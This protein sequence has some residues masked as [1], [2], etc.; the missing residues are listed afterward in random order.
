MQHVNKYII[1]TL[2]DVKTLD[3]KI[4]ELRDEPGNL[5]LLLDVMGMI[6][7]DAESLVQKG[8]MIK[9][10]DIV[11][12]ILANALKADQIK[13]QD[14][15]LVLMYLENVFAPPIYWQYAILRVHQSLHEQKLIE[16]A[17]TIEKAHMLNDV[18]K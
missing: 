3:V 5:D 6:C 2:E 17:T 12:Y 4:M 16:V 1:R 7:A 8:E 15:G 11:N 13:G 14:L 18:T 9:D 10:F